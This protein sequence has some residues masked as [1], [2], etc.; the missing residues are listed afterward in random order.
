MYS[1]GLLGWGWG[2]QLPSSK[3]RDES[4]KDRNS[5]I[6]R[7]PHPVG[8]PGDQQAQDGRRPG[9]LR[10]ALGRQRGLEQVLPARLH[11]LLAPALIPAD[12]KPY[13]L[14]YRK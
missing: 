6:R 12:T 10:G 4:V 9:D 7:A 13:P 8:D 11:R 5:Q 14:V 3:L 2:W 1:I